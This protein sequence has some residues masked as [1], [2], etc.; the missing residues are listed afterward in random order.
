MWDT[1]TGQ[2]SLSDTVV[3]RLGQ[4]TV[5]L[6]GGQRALLAQVH[7]PLF[8][9]VAPLGGLTPDT[10]CRPITIPPTPMTRFGN[11]CYRRYQEPR[12]IDPPLLAPA[13]TLQDATVFFERDRTQW[14]GPNSPDVFYVLTAPDC[15]FQPYA[16]LVI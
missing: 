15:L 13:G 9:F 4:D 11:T 14:R 2:L 3:S 5:L 16:V 6:R 8:G 7:P 12:R 10:T 1:T